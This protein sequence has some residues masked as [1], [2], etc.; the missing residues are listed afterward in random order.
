M[1]GPETEKSHRTRGT[2]K[3]EY[4]FYDKYMA[5]KGLDIGYRGQTSRACPV[6]PSAIGIDLDYPGYDG[7]ILPFPD[8]SQDYVF[9]SHVLEHLD[10]PFGTI[11]EWYRVLKLGGHLVICVPHQ[12]LYEKKKNPPSKWNRDHKQFYLPSDLLSYLETVLPTN[13]WR[14]RHCRDNDDGYDY[15]IPP[16]Q[17]AGGCYEIECVIQKIQLPT[18]EIK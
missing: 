4:G 1:R 13:G 14:L 8:Q 2:A 6:L 15:S 10:N 7:L 16:E 12:D 18:W 17:H 5:G 3:F 9:A 11:R